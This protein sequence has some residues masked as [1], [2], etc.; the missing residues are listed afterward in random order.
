[1]E[2]ISS[3][4]L[5]ISRK[6]YTRAQNVGIIKQSMAPSVSITLVAMAHGVNANQNTKIIAEF[7]NS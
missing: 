5:P 4:V 3:F 1:M 2:E 7:F 6:Q